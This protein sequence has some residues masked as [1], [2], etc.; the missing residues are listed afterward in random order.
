ME[1]KPEKLNPQDRDYNNIKQ[2]IINIST[3]QGVTLEN[4]EEKKC[5]DRTGVNVYEKYHIGNRELNRKVE[6]QNGHCL[7]K[8]SELQG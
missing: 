4:E 1:Y 7:K 3:K 2:V 6:E 5:Q 8:K